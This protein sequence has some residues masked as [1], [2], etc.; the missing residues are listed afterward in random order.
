MKVIMPQ[1]DAATYRS[2]VFW[3]R[4]FFGGYYRI[5][6][7]FLIPALATRLKARSKKAALGKGSV[8]SFEGERQA[9]LSTYDTAVAGAS[10]WLAQHLISSV[11]EGQAWQ[12]AEASQANNSGLLEAN[13]EYS[14]EL[15]NWAAVPGLI[16]QLAEE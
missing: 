11:A 13:Q 5:A 1:L 3:L 15:A 8:S 14:G 7:N 10:S 6:L 2:Q 9:A 16:A 12:Q 4:V